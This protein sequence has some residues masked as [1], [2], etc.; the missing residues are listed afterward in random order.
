[1]P[2]EIFIQV[3]K[4]RLI[5]YCEVKDSKTSLVLWLA[6]KLPSCVQAYLVA[7]SA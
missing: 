1:M 4:K 6:C 7:G 3:F 5:L 2:V